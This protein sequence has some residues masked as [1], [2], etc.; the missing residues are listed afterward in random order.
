MKKRFVF[1]II[2]VLLIVLIMLFVFLAIMNKVEI[3]T[4]T[5]PPSS[6][7]KLDIS[8][9]RIPSLGETA[10]ITAMI[11]YVNNESL[12]TTAQIKIP[13]G[14]EL[15]SGDPIWNGT[16]KRSFEFDIGVRAIKVGNWAIE[17]IARTPP[18]GESFFGGRDFIYISVGRYIS[19]TRESPFPKKSEP[20]AAGLNCATTERPHS[21]IFTLFVNKIKQFIRGF[22]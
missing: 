10:K 19:Y 8:I 6:P 12:N 5:P 13:E 1:L 9:S 15:I 17:G 14:F 7:M 22:N 11:S 16:L 20:C 2:A 21:S 4:A 3:K 18:T